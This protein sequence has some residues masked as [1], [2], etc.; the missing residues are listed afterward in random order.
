[1][2]MTQ[3][4]LINGQDVNYDKVITNK[5]LIELCSNITMY[6]GF[7]CGHTSNEGISPVSWIVMGWKLK[8]FRR[9]KMFTRVRVETWIQSFTKVRILRNYVVYDEQENVI[10]KAA[11]EWVAVDGESGNFLRITPQLLAPYSIL[12]EE[13]NFPGYRFPGICSADMPVMGTKSVIPGLQMADYNR[14]VH[15]SEYLH[16]AAEICPEAMTA[17]DVEVIYRTQILPGEPVLLELIHDEGKQKVAIKSPEDQSLHALL[18][19]GGSVTT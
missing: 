2:K 10:A 12:T 17:D 18:I 9:A 3:T 14:H 11:G 16:L 1:M 15:N 4:V 6:D 5:A 13:N 7:L 8:V 19:I